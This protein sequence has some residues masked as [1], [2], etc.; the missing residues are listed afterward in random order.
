[1]VWS[2]RDFASHWFLQDLWQVKNLLINATLSKHV[3]QH[4]N[5]AFATRWKTT[6]W[7]DKTEMSN[8]CI[9]TVP[10]KAGS[11]TALFLELLRWW[12]KPWFKHIP[13]WCF[14]KNKKHK[15]ISIHKIKQQGKKNVKRTYH[16][17]EIYQHCNLEVVFEL[18]CQCYFSTNHS[19]RTGASYHN[20]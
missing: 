5:N 4:Q 18:L 19:R 11:L 16:L 6:P 15:E 7:Y 2:F 20:S 9:I 12:T 1:M 13:L 3:K 17:A 10:K 14:I 8:T